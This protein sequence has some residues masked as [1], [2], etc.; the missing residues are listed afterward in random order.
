MYDIT[1]TRHTG[2]SEQLVTGSEDLPTAEDDACRVSSEGPWAE[3]L[4]KDTETGGVASRY[5]S[6]VKQPDQDWAVRSGRRAQLA[7]M[8]K[9]RLVA[10][11][12][13][14]VRRPDG[15]VSRDPQ[16][17]APLR[18]WTKDDIIAWIMQTEFPATP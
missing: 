10:F 13:T 15:T 14:G 11:C 6:G 18:D 1:G 8:S 4:V 12:R 7:R 9:P 17:T 3:V 5:V 2:E 16:G